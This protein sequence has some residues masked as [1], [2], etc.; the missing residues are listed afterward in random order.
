MPYC[1]FAIFGPAN[2]RMVRKLRLHGQVLTK[3]TEGK[4]VLMPVEIAGPPDI[5]VWMESWA[6]FSTAMVML[7]AVD[8]GIL[9]LYKS[10]IL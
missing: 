2:N 9:D 7:D 8:L 1:D 6:V 3:D 5:D 4:P 10:R